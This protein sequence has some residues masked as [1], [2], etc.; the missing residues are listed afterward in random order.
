MSPAP[1]LSVKKA[2]SPIAIQP[3][4]VIDTPARRNAEYIAN[5]K[6]TTNRTLRISILASFI[7][8]ALSRCLIDEIHCNKT[9]V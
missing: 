4:T 1:K 7:E 9:K 8:R 5:A 3:C 2:P 6:D